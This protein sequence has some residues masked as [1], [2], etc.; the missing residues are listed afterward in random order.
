M[1]KEKR[2]E[3]APARTRQICAA[4]RS[5]LR[6]K[7]SCGKWPPPAPVRTRPGT[8]AFPPQKSPINLDCSK[9][10]I[11][12][13]AEAIVDAHHEAIDL[14]LDV[15][16]ERRCAHGR[17]E[18][19]ARRAEVEVVVF[20]EGRPVACEGPFDAAA[21]G[22]SRWRRAC[23][24]EGDARD[25][26]DGVIVAHPRAAALGINQHRGVHSHADA[27]RHGG[28]AWDFGVTV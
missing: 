3:P 24:P 2:P 17:R 19:H 22:P 21:D 1:S 4:S 11:A 5:T 25:R 8:A 6:L 20:G 7:W 18:V 10:S 12:D 23:V 15:D 9:R 16:R 13:G 14:L 28:E 27:T 26:R